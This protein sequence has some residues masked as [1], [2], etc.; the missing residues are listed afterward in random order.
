MKISQKINSRCVADCYISTRGGHL[1]EM[2]LLLQGETAPIAQGRKRRAHCLRGSS[3]QEEMLA[4][5]SLSMQIPARRTVAARRC[6]WPRHL[7]R[8]SQLKLAA[9]E[10]AR[11][12]RVSLLEGGDGGLR[13]GS[14]AFFPFLILTAARSVSDAALIRIISLL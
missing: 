4:R 9:N 7:P 6:P 12:A 1:A 13:A 5:S 3:Q 14:D 2:R 11:P 8:R 10:S